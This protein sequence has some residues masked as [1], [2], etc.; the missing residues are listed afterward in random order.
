MEPV[1]LDFDDVDEHQNEDQNQDAS[2]VV[3]LFPSVVAVD[4]VELDEDDVKGEAQV[5]ENDSR[6]VVRQTR[7]SEG[8]CHEEEN[9]AFADSQERLDCRFLVRLPF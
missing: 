3:S 4:E 1:R 6:D 2:D 7:H 9:S 5:E 8:H